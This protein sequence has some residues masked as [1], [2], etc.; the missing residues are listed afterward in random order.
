MA[1]SYRE[2]FDNIL[3]DLAKLR[4]T[5]KDSSDYLEICKRVASKV[6]PILAGISN[7]DLEPESKEKKLLAEIYSQILAEEAYANAAS[8]LRSIS[9]LH[10]ILNIE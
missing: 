5:R 3:S 7:G 10:R 6:E 9:E 4:D 1:G 8:D 2:V